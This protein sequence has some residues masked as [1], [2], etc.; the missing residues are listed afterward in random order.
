MK[1]PLFAHQQH[2]EPVQA[3]AG[4]AQMLDHHQLDTP[5]TQLLAG[6]QRLAQVADLA[7]GQLLQLQQIGSQ[8][9]GAGQRAVFQKIGD[10]G[11]DDAPLVGMPHHGVAKIAGMR[12]ERLE[13]SHRRQDLLPL[14]GRA[15]IAAQ[16]RI[17]LPQHT[18]V[19]Q[20]RHQLA[21]MAVWHHHPLPAGAVLGMVGKLH[22][23]DG[24]H[25]QPHAAHGKH[26]GAVAGAAEHHVGLDGENS[27]HADSQKNG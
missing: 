15:E 27:L 25:L 2:L 13:V 7:A 1:R 16:D 4:A 3:Q 21:D 5:V 8:Q 23:V 22:R 24:P 14:L 26:G 12:I 20:P 17:A 9:V 6:G 11:R 19:G 18:D 10:A